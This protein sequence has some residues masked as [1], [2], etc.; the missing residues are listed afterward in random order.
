ML[1]KLE[2]CEI[3]NTNQ[4]VSIHKN[5]AYMVANAG[6]NFI[7][8][9]DKDIENIMMSQQQFFVLPDYKIEDMGGIF[10]EVK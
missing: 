6:S 8:V 10:K 7:D 5:C 3:I 9:T 4:I 2:S 1:I